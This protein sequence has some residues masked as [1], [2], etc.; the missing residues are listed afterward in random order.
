M[1]NDA[2]RAIRWGTLAFDKM[3]APMPDRIRMPSISL[4]VA[5]SSPGCVIGLHNKLPWKLKSDLKRLK[6]ITDGHVVIMGRRTFES[7]GKPLRGRA[8]VVLSRRALLEGAEGDDYGEETQLCRAATIEAALRV[9]DVLSMC[10]N[11]DEIFVLGGEPVYDS[12][13]KDG[14]VNRVYLTEV[15]ASFPGDAYF[16][17]AFP[18]DG[19]IIRAREELRKGDTGDDYDSRFM[20]Y[21]ERGATRRY[22]TASG[23]EERLA[24]AEAR[25]TR[26]IQNND[27]NIVNY[28]RTHIER[29]D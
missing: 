1:T 10:R 27:S 29:E 17:A 16:R 22:E 24:P 26:Y 7:I 15:L 3:Q 23:L 18:D 14:L 5:R 20:I 2:A 6:R 4:I 25:L 9:A 28:E 13:L 12:F 8:N 19:W 21:D 11:R